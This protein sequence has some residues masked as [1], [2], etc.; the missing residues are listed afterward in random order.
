[1]QLA[2]DLLG[3]I[4]R[5]DEQRRDV[6]KR[7]STLVV[8]SKTTVTDVYGVGSVVAATV[9]GYV[10]D[11]GCCASKDAFAAYNATAPIEASSGNRHVY[12]LSLRRNRQMNHAIHMAAL[13][14]IRY[15]HTEG[16]AYYDLKIATG[17]QHR[18][19][20]RA[21][22]RKISDAVNRRL[23]EDAKTDAR[24]QASVREGNRGTTLSPAW[25]AHTPQHRIFGQA[26]PGPELSLRPRA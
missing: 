2:R 14:Q 23:V 6:K 18:S 9:L 11:I 20:L 21:L 1:M 3:E 24:R 26:T 12:R 15:P 7:L 25:P 4:S 8:A 5:V 22:K 19:A 10:G 13:T 17:M 16:H